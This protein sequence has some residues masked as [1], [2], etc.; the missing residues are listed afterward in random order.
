VLIALLL[1][2]G[3]GAGA[4]FVGAKITSATNNPLPLVGGLIIGL[5]SLF[6]APFNAKKAV[7]RTAHRSAIAYFTRLIEADPQNQA[8]YF[9]RGQTYL[10]LASEY[11][12]PQFSRRI[13]AKA[14]PD[15]DEAIR[16]VPTSAAAYVGRVNAFG[17][18]GQLK[19][20]IAEYTQAIERDPNHALAY[21]ARATA[22]NGLYQHDRSIPDATEAIRLAP[23]LYLGYDARGYGFWHRGNSTRTKAD[24]DQAIADFTEAIRL[25][26]RALD[27][28]LGRAQVYRALGDQPSAANDE[29]KAK[30]MT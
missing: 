5:F 12:W 28:Y 8:A 18:M 10:R 3:F 25:N 29:H 15:L 14:V 30:E 1:T 27:C 4:I 13:A 7:R 2:L 17:I 16:L 22:Y 21:C 9:N 6:F 23:D 19:E 26:P 11:S 24:Y 20:L